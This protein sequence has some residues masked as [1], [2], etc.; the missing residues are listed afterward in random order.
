MLTLTNAVV[1][2]PSRSEAC[3]AA[4]ARPEARLAP[5]NSATDRLNVFIVVRL[6]SL[7]P[8]TI[9][10][11]VSFALAPGRSLVPKALLNYTRRADLF[12]YAGSQS[13]F[14]SREL[15]RT[16]STRTGQIGK[17]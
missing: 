5:T 2:P 1:G 9:F 7:N 14:H 16:G 10:R 11:P 13:G 15:K 8:E 3:S 4:M 6:D 17:P 12:I